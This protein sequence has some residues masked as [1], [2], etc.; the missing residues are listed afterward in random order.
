MGDYFKI[1]IANNLNNTNMN[2]AHKEISL[3]LK[4]ADYLICGI[5]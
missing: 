4:D 3:K 5:P 1:V 2:Y